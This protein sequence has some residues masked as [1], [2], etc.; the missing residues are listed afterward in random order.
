MP[1]LS[2]IDKEILNKHKSGLKKEVL[3][4]LVKEDELIA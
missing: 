1:F 3:V 4:V 2:T